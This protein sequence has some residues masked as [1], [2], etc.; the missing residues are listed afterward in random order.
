MS[1]PVT[2]LKPTIDKSDE[3]IELLTTEEIETLIVG[4]LKANGDLGAAT[5]DLE[6]L[7]VWAKEARLNHHLLEMSLG[8]RLRALY[9]NGQLSF[10]PPKAVKA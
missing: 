3:H 10:C 7:I 4:A 9:K 1:N 6:K 2:T 8:G 5:E